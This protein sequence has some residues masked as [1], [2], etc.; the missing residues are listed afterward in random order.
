MMVYLKSV[1][2]GLAAVFVSVIVILI[3]LTVL[4]NFVLPRWGRGSGAVGFAFGPP[5]AVFFLAIVLAIF[6]IGF[7]WEFRRASGA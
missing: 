1:V 4:F 7:Y 3:G 6:A 5:Y 2:A